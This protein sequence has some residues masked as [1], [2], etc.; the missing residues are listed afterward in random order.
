MKKLVV[1]VFMATLYAFNG[2]CQ[3]IDHVFAPS[4]PLDVLSQIEQRVDIFMELN[5]KF[6]EFDKSIFPDNFENFE[7]NLLSY[8]AIE[9]SFRDLFNKV[10]EESE[11]LSALISDMLLDNDEKGV[12][13]TNEQFVKYMT[14]F[15]IDLLKIEERLNRNNRLELGV[16]NLTNKTN[17]IKNHITIKSP[18]PKV[19]SWSAIIVTDKIKALT[20]QCCDYFEWY[21]DYLYSINNAAD[22]SIGMTIKTKPVGSKL[23][24]IKSIPKDI[25]TTYY[26]E[27]IDL[28]ISD[29]NNVL[30]ILDT[31]SGELSRYNGLIHSENKRLKTIYE[32][33]KAAFFELRDTFKVHISE[34]IGETNVKIDSINKAL[35]NLATKVKGL[36]TQISV[37]AEDYQESD[38]QIKINEKIINTKTEE[39][40][41]LASDILALLDDIQ[42]LNVEKRELLKNCESEKATE[43]CVSDPSR[44]KEIHETVNKKIA[45]LEDLDAKKNSNIKIIYTKNEE[46]TALL[47]KSL[48]SYEKF[49]ELRDKYRLLLNSYAIDEPVARKALS[50]LTRTKYYYEGIREKFLVGIGEK[51]SLLEENLNDLLKPVMVKPVI[52]FPKLPD[53]HLERINNL[54]IDNW[55][56]ISIFNN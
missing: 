15:R 2:F 14:Q 25:R 32:K 42:I 11:V 8:Y 22:E 37:A 28:V 55:K 35:W 34:N 31:I 54:Q 17:K 1:C 47:E 43:T 53:T 30:K 46:N 33:D 29:R 44:L 41:D 56:S 18:Y 9:D 21:N 12:S 6:V 16:T 52:Q 5:P 45:E 23:R 24:D 26:N 38:A 40:D 20:P 3:S 48:I 10:P 19:D 49:I 51:L 27:V 36:N 4:L 7:V 39:N 50:L 13:N